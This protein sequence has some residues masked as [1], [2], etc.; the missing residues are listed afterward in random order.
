MEKDIQNIFSEGID[1]EESKKCDGK[2]RKFI[3]FLD[4]VKADPSN[5]NF[6]KSSTL[7]IE[8]YG[9][10]EGYLATSNLL[11]NMEIEIEKRIDAELRD[12]IKKMRDELRPKIEKDMNLQEMRDLLDRLS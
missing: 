1:L 2:F 8:K 4:D 5:S 9:K 3:G 6:F 10:F 12:D 11:D 7:E